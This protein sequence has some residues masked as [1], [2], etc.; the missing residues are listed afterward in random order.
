MAQ[1]FLLAK[2]GLPLSEEARANLEGALD[3]RFPQAWRAIGNGSYLLATTM[4]R[5]TQDIST[6]IGITDGH[7]G[8][9]LVTDI[10][11][12]FGWADRSLWEWIGYQ[13]AAP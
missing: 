6:E 12:Y 4:V 13:H 2:I 10:G 1:I 9:F 3:M 11:S 5:I 7:F 8:E